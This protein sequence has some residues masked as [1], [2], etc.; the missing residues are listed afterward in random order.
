M[1]PPAPSV[2]EALGVPQPQSPARAPVADSPDA[3]SRQLHAPGYV[4]DV[5]P[6]RPPPAGRRGG[7]RGEAGRDEAER[8]GPGRR[9]GE[10][11]QAER[12]GAER[13]A[14]GRH[15]AEQR[16][17]GQRGTAA[18]GAP[19]PCIV[20]LSR[21]CDAE[22]TAVTGLL[23]K[24]G[25]RVARINADEL[26]SAGLLIDPG[27]RAFLRDGRWL[28]PTVVWKRHFAARAIEGSAGPAYDMFLRD[29]WRATAGQLAA[30]SP[31]AIGMRSPGR[32]EQ[33]LAAQERQIAIPRTVV[34][35]DPAAAADLLGAELAGADLPGADP[36]GTGRRV[37]IKAVDEHF[38]EAS[39]GRLSGVFPVVVS[40]GEPRSGLPV[41]GL[42]VP[43]L[44]APGLPVMVQEYVEHDAELRVYYVDGRVLGFEVGKET[45][46]D[47]WLA[48][49]RVT[50]RHAD[51]PR[52]VVV[53]V[54]ALAEDFCLRYGAF[55][56]L[57]RAGTP[58]FLEVNTDGDWLW[59]ERR[60]RTTTVTAAVARMLC[61]LHRR[62]RPSPAPENGGADT[63][64]LL[65]F[66]GHATGIGGS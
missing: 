53:A 4:L 19:V 55:D 9:G 57:V 51:L 65:A 3:F 52:A 11:Q 6:S 23:G 28:A 10:G 39:P 35:T 8:Q 36:C 44:P 60:A 45:A 33:L 56:F 20:L 40:R 21:S 34:T 63:F 25:I 16:G 13:E 5:R 17:T 54:R 47:P 26:E 30:V 7:K 27:R 43:G 37:L 62:H 46:A 12:Q 22:L 61:D 48:P 49:G 15:G 32:L 18:A 66:L 50:A 42:A 38:V 59:A 31:V 41:P 2:P 29:S 14:A 24:A 1:P 64:N 58:V